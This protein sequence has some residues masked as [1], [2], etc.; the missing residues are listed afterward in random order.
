MYQESCLLA[1]G[2]VQLLLLQWLHQAEKE[3]QQAEADSAADGAVLSHVE[4]Q[5]FPRCSAVF[6]GLL[7]RTVHC[8]QEC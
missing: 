1:T 8:L 4:P 3:S 2:T 7:L 6:L 5:A